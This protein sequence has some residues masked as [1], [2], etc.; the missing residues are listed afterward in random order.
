MKPIMAEA[1]QKEIDHIKGVRATEKLLSIKCFGTFEVFYDGDILPFKRKKTKEL[2]AILVDRN[3]SGMTAKQLCTVLFPDD[4]N[5]SRNAGYLRQLV[6]DLKNT[7]KAVGAS[8]VFC[9]NSPYYRIDTEKVNCDYFSFLAEG[10]P[11]FYGEYMAQYSW[12]E[13]TCGMLLTR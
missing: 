8:E 2:L 13:E 11:D 1:V 6:L 10:K 4:M 5:D 9:H 3:G 12:A 7:L